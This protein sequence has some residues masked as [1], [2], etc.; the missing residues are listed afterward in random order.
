MK[1]WL[2]EL[3]CDELQ[4][5]GQSG[6][7]VWYDAGGTLKPIVEQALPQGVRLLP[8]Q[9][10][11]LALRFALEG[12]DPQFRQRWVVYVPEKAPR[13]SWLRDWELLGAHWDMDLLELLRRKANLKVTPRLTELLR[14]QP[15]NARDLV[16]EWDALLDEQAVSEQSL[17]EALLAL[18]LGLTRWQPEEA[19]L[20]FVTDPSSGARLEQRGLWAAFKGR[21]QQWAG[22]ARLPDAATDLRKRLEAAILLSE[23]AAAVP[24]NIVASWNDILPAAPKQSVV[25]GIAKVW[26]EREDLRGGYLQAAKRVEKEYSLAKLLVPNEPLLRCETCRVIDDLWLQ[27]LAHVVAADGSNLATSATR[28]EEIAARRKKGFW[29]RQGEAPYWGAIH[30]AVQLY[31][32]CRAALADIGALTGVTALEQRYCAEDGWWRLDLWALELAAQAKALSPQERKRYADPAWHIYARYLDQLSR[33][34]A[35]AVQREG[36]VTDQPR[37][38]S[39]YVTGKRKTAILLVDGLRYDL[40]HRFA[41][42]LPQDEFQVTLH[43]SHGLLPSITEVG[44]SA[45][46]PG[47]EAGLAV[48]VEGA[49]VRV[50][51]GKADVSTPQGRLAWL[52]GRL[53][54]QAKVVRLDEVEG[55]DLDGVE[56]LV[57]QSREIDQFG[58][59]VADLAPEGLLDMVQ[60]LVAPIRYLREKGFSTIQITA[61]HGFLFFPPGVEPIALDAGIAKVCKRRFAIGAHPEGCLLMASKELGLAGSEQFAFPIG[62]AV[63]ALQGAVGAFLHGGLSLQ[64]CVI[65]VLEVKCVAPEEKVTVVMELP[66]QLT[67]RIALVTLRVEKPTLLTKP[68]RVQ[69]EINSKRSELVEMSVSRQEYRVKLPWLG[70]DESVPS[71]ATV[72]L[73]DAESGQVLVEQSL[74]V[75]MVV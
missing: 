38:W 16:Q 22:W 14:E 69:V 25:A 61:D 63:F 8:F 10:S 64:E 45:L 74:P 73:L 13:E 15:Q 26:R 59:F 72:R 47:A 66:A 5:Q 75:A 12:E 56:L 57:V 28:V 51:L 4:H 30:L 27:E 20:A 31:Q 60:R 62:L 43:A 53:P 23:L 41:A 3:L 33:R 37:F 48:S 1:R 6:L 50:E 65:P 11:Y 70:F 71:T 40:A 55:S 35:E 36:W 46:L 58:T 9:G 29:A 44:M 54:K 32:S 2:R 49:S 34:L 68:R 7:L 52:Q 18:A 17:L 24:D 39:Q 19:V 42:L 21:L 67:S